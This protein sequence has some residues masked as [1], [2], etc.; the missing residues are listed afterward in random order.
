MNAG[1][2]LLCGL[3]K[4]LRRA[5]QK[6]SMKT[7]RK[8]NA[9]L[10]PVLYTSH[11]M[12]TFCFKLYTSKNNRR[13]KRLIDI[14]GLIYNHCIALHRRYYR[15]Y[16]KYIHKYTLM[17]HLVKVKRTKRFSYFKKLDAQAIQ[18]IVSRIDRAYQL[19]WLRRGKGQKASAPGFKR[20]K[21][22]KSFTLRQ[23]GWKLN[24]AAN[25]VIIC[26]KRYKYI[27][28][29]NVEGRVKTVTVKRDSLG[30]AY[31]Y[32]ACDVELHEAVPRTGRI[33]GYDFGLKKFLTASDGK[34][35]ESPQFFRMSVKIVRQK[36]KE[37]SHKKVGSKRRE[38][39]R[40]GLAHVYKRI[41]DRRKDF[42]YKT[43][44]QICREYALVCIEQLNTKSMRKIWG[45][46]VSDLSF[47]SFV[48][49]LKYEACKLGTRVVETDVYYPSSQL[50]SECGY[51]NRAVKNLRIRRWTCPHCGVEHDRDRNAAINIL[52]AGAS[53]HAGEPVRPE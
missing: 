45:R 32:L 22:Y 5:V 26:K 14:A 10:I 37:L 21:K 30:D 46:K 50:C 44:L 17:N 51:K 3:M 18:D 48:Q 27:N 8:V 34:D 1:V 43:A 2:Y 31:I 38:R 24:E 13:L 23:S 9:F 28:T 35:V 41:S 47:W 6:K 39:A 49:I 29:R 53:A 11:M 36:S 20:I 16:G 7:A 42:H 40:K 4:T 12:K 19:F 33:V 15:L 25:T 52:R